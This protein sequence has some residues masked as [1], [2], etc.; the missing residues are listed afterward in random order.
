MFKIKNNFKKIN[1][2]FDTNYHLI[3]IYYLHLATQA[4][5]HITTGDI[6]NNEIDRCKS[7]ILFNTKDRKV[8]GT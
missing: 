5:G 7:S 2:N 6:Y 8:V 4:P 3:T 1:N